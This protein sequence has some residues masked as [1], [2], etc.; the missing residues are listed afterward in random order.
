MR[1]SIYFSISKGSVNEQQDPRLIREVGDLVNKKLYVLTNTAK[2][3]TP[4]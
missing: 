4:N 3:N 2:M 1:D